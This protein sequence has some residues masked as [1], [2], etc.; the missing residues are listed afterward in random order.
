L[1]SLLGQI[2]CCQVVLLVFSF[3]F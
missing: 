1:M 2:K 3:S